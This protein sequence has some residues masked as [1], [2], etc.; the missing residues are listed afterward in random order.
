MSSDAWTQLPT[1]D[2][3]GGVLEASLDQLTPAAYEF[4]VDA[5]DKAGNA[6]SSQ[7]AHDGTDF[8]VHVTY[9]ATAL[10]AQFAQTAGGLTTVD[11]GKGV[12][13]LGTLKDASGQPLGNQN[14]KVTEHFAAGSLQD[15]RAQIVHTDAN[16]EYTAQLGSGPSRAIDVA[17][18]GAGRLQ[19]SH[20]DTAAAAEGD[21]R[22]DPEGEEEG[23]GRKASQVQGPGDDRRRS[24]APGRKARRGRRQGR[25]ALEADR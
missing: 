17:F 21:E 2:I 10:K 4:K 11:Y 8:V 25:R 1:N 19:Q 6:G 20:I 3:G 16:G 14:V 23:Q 22:R 12:D 7:K 24:D 13:V 18:D 15:Q 9:E 5:S